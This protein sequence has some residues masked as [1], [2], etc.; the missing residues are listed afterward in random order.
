MLS[1]SEPITAFWFADTTFPKVLSL[2]LNK[3]NSL[4]TFDICSPSLYHL[5]GWVLEKFGSYPH[6]H[7]NGSPPKATSRPSEPT[8]ILRT[9]FSER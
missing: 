7:V 4:R 2:A 1:K 8:M 9:R 6:S 5:L 3:R